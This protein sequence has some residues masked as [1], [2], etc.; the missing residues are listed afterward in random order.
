MNRR[1]ICALL[2][3]LS[4]AGAVARAAEHYEVIVERDVPA[5]M[6]DGVVLH[7]DI[8]RP[9]A[10]GKF[11]VL[12]TRTPY[13]KR[14]ESDFGP[15]PRPGATWWWLRMCEGATPR[16]GSGTPSST[17]R[18]R[19][20]HGGVG[21]RPALLQWQG[22]D[23][24]RLLCGRNA[25]AGRHCLTAAP[26]G[27][28]FPIMTASNYHEGWTYQGGAFALWF[29]QSWTSGLAMKRLTAAWRGI[30]GLPLGHELAACRLPPAKR[31]H[32]R[33]RGKVLFRLACSPRLRRILE[34]TLD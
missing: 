23:V 8:Y 24:Q 34:K 32:F 2:V 18:G 31:R 12:L 17:N 21:S 3:T 20:R 15:W 26:G 25:D 6:R 27:E 5:K 33:G 16:K 14:G 30:Q 22:R 9:K 19:L 4:C 29:S 7:A 13:D 28:C 11:P 1:V 10:D